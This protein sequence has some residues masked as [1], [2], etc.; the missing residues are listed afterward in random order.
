M[1]FFLKIGTSRYFFI[2]IN[3]K[4]LPKK[5]FTFQKPCAMMYVV[6]VALSTIFDEKNLVRK[7]NPGKIFP[8]G[9]INFNQL[10]HGNG[11]SWDK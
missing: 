3:S 5:V 6:K 4:Y 9:F 1:S 2:E 7:H 10:Y 8:T 11:R